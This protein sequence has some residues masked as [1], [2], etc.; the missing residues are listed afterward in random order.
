MDRPITIIQPGR[1]GDILLVLPIAH[2]LSKSR[3]VLWPVCEEYQKMVRQLS[4]ERVTFITIDNI[5][6]GQ[7]MK[8]KQ[9]ALQYVCRDRDMLD[10]AIG[11]G[12]A[13]LDGEWKNTGLPFD[14]WKYRTAGITYEKKYELPKALEG[15][16]TRGYD[17]CTT[18]MDQR[19][20]GG[21]YIVT[22]SYGSNG[23]RFS[24][25]KII[26]ERFGDVLAIEIQQIGKYTVFDWLPI[27]HGADAILCV[28]SCISNL[29][30]QMGI[31]PTMGRFF[32]PWTEY[33]SL[34]QLHMLTP[35]MSEDWITV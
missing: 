25:N 20:H 27:I 29:V 19:I 17:L 18:L 13:A 15:S 21:R 14:I 3:S 28:D 16:K 22:H 9:N 2:E 12:D 26:S 4:M 30:D 23:R 33:Y 11:F 34:E 5:E 10:L 32:H 8:A 35:K 6:D 24:F 1:I 31:R 7:A